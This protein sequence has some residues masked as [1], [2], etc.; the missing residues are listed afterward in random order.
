[1]KN[2]IIITLTIIITTLLL[3]TGVYIAYDQGYIFPK[4][5]KENTYMP[6]TYEICDN[7]SCIYL[8][9][10]IHVGD[11]R[12]NKFDKKLINLYDKSKYLAV[13]LDTQ[14]VNMDLDTFI[15]SPN[16]TPSDILN[17]DIQ[18]KLTDF[19]STRGLLTYEQLKYF[20]IGYLANYISL[21]PAME[22]N[23]TSSGV[24]E[25]FLYLAHNDNK[26]II[27]L[28]TYEEQLSLLLDYSNE[29]YIDQITYTLDNY[30]EGKMELKNLYEEYLNAN[31]TKLEKLINEEEEPRTEE[32]REYQNKMITERNQKMSSKVEEFLNNDKEVFMI[33]GLAHVI[34]EDGIIELLQDKNYKIK[35]VS[36]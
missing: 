1:M 25:H 22:L 21:L 26:E 35:I 30:E 24:D 19:L 20:K 2:K 5:A 28:E 33:V 29:F 17:E 11:S 4:E 14:K 9:G 36:N 7:D 6:L 27:E 13:E 10:S 34:G 12:V 18:Q 16:E 8:L 23:L 3:G 32:E 15:A 31:K